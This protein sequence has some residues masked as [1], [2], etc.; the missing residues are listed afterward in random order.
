MTMLSDAYTN[1][2]YLADYP[3]W[4]E[5]QAEWKAVQI[6]RLLKGKPTPS[7]VCDIGCGAGYVI[8]ELSRDYPPSVIWDGFDISP[9]S[10]RLGCESENVRLALMG[11]IDP[12]VQYDL[13]LCL[14]VL[15][16][17]ENCWEFLR[18]LR[19]RGSH[20]V[21]HIP[22]D[23]NAQIAVRPERMRYLRNVT[24]HFGYFTAESALD[25]LRR[26]GYRPQDWF[27]TR[28]SHHRARW[29]RPVDWLRNVLFPVAPNFTVRLFGGYSLMVFAEADA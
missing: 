11:E 21:F 25:T 8:S 1:G 9:D 5:H 20:F 16:H 22:L 27:Y 14:D 15:E 28:I 24:R 13:V 12:T 7:R 17:V 2:A 18:E 29:F 6:R 3:D 23:F 19:N 26:C 4:L 10:L